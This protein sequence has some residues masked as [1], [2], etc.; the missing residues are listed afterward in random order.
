MGRGIKI[1]ASQQPPATLA[2]TSAL[3]SVEA[4]HP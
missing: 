1:R 4:V 3:M 2:V